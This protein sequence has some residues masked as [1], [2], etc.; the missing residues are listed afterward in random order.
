M[1]AYLYRSFLHHEKH[2]PPEGQCGH[3]CKPSAMTTK[4][5]SRMCWITCSRNLANYVRTTDERWG[6]RWQGCRDVISRHGLY[7]TNPR[8]PMRD[9]QAINLKTRKPSAIFFNTIYFHHLNKTKK[10][11]KRCTTATGEVLLYR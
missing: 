11:T 5:T 10:R 6:W 2:L 3:A 4:D 9:T 7:P 1:A 8:K